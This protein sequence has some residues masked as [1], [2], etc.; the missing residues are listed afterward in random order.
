MLEQAKLY[1]VKGYLLLL[2]ERIGDSMTHSNLECVM[3][4]G[5]GTIAALTLG[6]ASDVQVGFVPE[7]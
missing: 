6:L 1:R 3:Q 7:G 4:P 2:S 5:K